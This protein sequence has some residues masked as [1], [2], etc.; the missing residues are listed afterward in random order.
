MEIIN[1]NI[2]NIENECIKACVSF[3]KK[4]NMLNL[5]NGSYEICGNDIYC[6]VF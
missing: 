5:T 2:I 6:N 3:C 4:N 1:K